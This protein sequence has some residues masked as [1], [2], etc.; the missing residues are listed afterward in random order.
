MI[1]K[2]CK[3]MEHFYLFSLDI[4]GKTLIK[5]CFKVCQAKS[6]IFGR[7]NPDYKIFIE[8]IVCTSEFINYKYFNKSLQ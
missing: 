7:I 1:S 3:A 2:Y 5:S 8:N 6:I 4:C